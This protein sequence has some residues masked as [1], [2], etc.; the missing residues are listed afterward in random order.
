MLPV[1]ISCYKEPELEMETVSV[2]VSSLV[3]RSGLEPA[4]MFGEVEGA[5]F[6]SQ[7]GQPGKADYVL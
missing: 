2:W 4:L 5:D 6:P 3:G 1:K 7:H